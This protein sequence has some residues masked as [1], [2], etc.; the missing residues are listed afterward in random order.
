MPVELLDK[1]GD[2]KLSIPLNS[3]Q[4]VEPLS[5]IVRLEADSNYSK[6]FFSNRPP[7]Y[8]ARTLSVFERLLRKMRFRR[9]HHSHLVHLEKVKKFDESQ[10]ALEMTDGTQVPVSRRK[11]NEMADWVENS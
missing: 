9:V 11:K 8:S 10:N 3:G 6:V 2:P 5:D 1:D 4:V 7:I